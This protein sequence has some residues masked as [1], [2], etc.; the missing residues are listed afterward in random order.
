MHARGVLERQSLK[1]CIVRHAGARAARSVYGRK[2]NEMAEECG[3]YVPHVSILIIYVF[4]PPPPPLFELSAFMALSILV[5]LLYTFA[6]S[7]PLSPLPERLTHICIYTG[8]AFFLF[9]CAKC[10]KVRAARE[11][12]AFFLLSSKRRR[13][14]APVLYFFPPPIR[15]TYQ[16]LDSKRKVKTDEDLQFYFKYIK[17]KRI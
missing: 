7:R 10:R 5:T 12:R 1:Y 9:E 4:L 8:L 11:H 6:T 15:S 13:A 3:K 2:K 17:R 16:I 14:P